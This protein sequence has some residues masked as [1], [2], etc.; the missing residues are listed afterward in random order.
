[1]TDRP[2]A[3]DPVIAE[4]RRTHRQPVASCSYWARL[5][6]VLK[7][8]SKVSSVWCSANWAAAMRRLMA[9]SRREIT[10]H[11]LPAE[12]VDAVTADPDDYRVPE[13]AV[14][15]ASEVIVSGDT[16]LLQLGTFRDIPVMTGRM[17]TSPA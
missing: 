5:I 15:A 1:M 10:T 6:V 12:R 4:G 11:V 2:S 3:S 7:A 16:D 8:Q 14:A 13:C 9:R 17:S